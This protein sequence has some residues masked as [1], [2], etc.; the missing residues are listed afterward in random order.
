MLGRLR[1]DLGMQENAEEGLQALFDN[2]TIAELAK[3]LHGLGE[4]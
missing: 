1:T 3:T 2:P 4:A